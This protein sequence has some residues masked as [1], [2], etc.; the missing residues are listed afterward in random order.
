MKVVK[1]VKVV[2]MDRNDE[3]GGDGRKIKVVMGRWW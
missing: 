1:I 3:G 2:V